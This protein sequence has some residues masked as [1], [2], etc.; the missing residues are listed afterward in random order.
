MGRGQFLSYCPYRII[1]IVVCFE[2]QD[3]F[4]IEHP[5][6]SGN[7]FRNLLPMTDYQQ[8]EAKIK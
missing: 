3:I 1:I 2:D 4:R 5:G 7:L 8:L 6:G